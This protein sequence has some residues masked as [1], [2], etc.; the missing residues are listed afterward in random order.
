MFAE[1]KSPDWG[2]NR[3]G[4]TICISGVGGKTLIRQAIALQSSK[5]DRRA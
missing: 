3:W 1:K 5:G 2:W 4:W